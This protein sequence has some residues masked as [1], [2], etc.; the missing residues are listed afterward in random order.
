MYVSNVIELVGTPRASIFPEDL[1]LERNVY[2]N[3]Q[4]KQ[5]KS[6][7]GNIMHLNSRARA[8]FTE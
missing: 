3:Q 8:R 7:T 2:I 6:I 4:M 5:V 1:L